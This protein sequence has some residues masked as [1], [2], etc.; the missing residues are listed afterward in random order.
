[1]GGGWRCRGWCRGCKGCSRCRSRV[2]RGTPCAALP[3]CPHVHLTPPPPCTACRRREALVRRR[4]SRSVR[5]RCCQCTTRWPCSLRRCGRLF[6]DGGECGCRLDLAA[7]PACMHCCP[8]ALVVA[9]PRCC[10]QRAPFRFI[11]AWT[12]A[13]PTHNQ[14]PPTNHPPAP[15]MHD[16]PVRMLA[17]GML[18]AIVPWQ[19][20][21]TFF[22]RRLRRR[23]TEEAL[24]KH[25]AGEGKKWWH[26]LV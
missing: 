2:H 17:K 10:Q 13:P 23:L 18:R 9:L 26:M 15:Q 6:T 1:M 3:R 21:R 19:Q 11:P 4:P 25:I 7:G 12:L 20:A 8:A 16:G 24:L 22:V 5:A 14:L